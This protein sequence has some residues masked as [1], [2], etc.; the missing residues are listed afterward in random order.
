M[1]T[2]NVPLRAGFW[3]RAA[4]LLIDTLVIGAAGGLLGYSVGRAYL[5][6]FPGDYQTP[7]RLMALVVLVCA[8]LYSAWMESSARGATLGKQALGLRVQRSDGAPLG[9]WHASARAAGKLLSGAL[10]LIGFFLAAGREKRALHD[11]M[12]GTLVVRVS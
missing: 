9:F 8:W 11:R 1:Q 10:L 6:T 3:R 5:V 7:G 2:M 12:A 4:A